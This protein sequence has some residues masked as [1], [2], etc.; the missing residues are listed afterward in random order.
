MKHLDLE[1]DSESVLSGNSEGKVDSLQ[2]ALNKLSDEFAFLGCNKSSD[3]VLENAKSGKLRPEYLDNL[4]SNLPELMSTQWAS[5]IKYICVA[6]WAIAS[7]EAE[8]GRSDSAWTTLLRTQYYLG[9]LMA[10]YEFP[11][12]R[13]RARKGGQKR[14]ENRLRR[15]SM[16]H[17]LVIS[18]LEHQRPVK[19]WTSEDDTV[20]TIAKNLAILIEDQGWILLET[21]FSSREVSASGVSGSHEEELINDLRFVIQNLL[22]ENE[23]IKKKYKE[24]CQRVRKK[25]WTRGRAGY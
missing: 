23:E 13:S 15:E 19:G 7:Y 4:I 1:T 11:H 8:K 20:M 17:Y 16:L 9:L 6:G 24:T 25:R 14:H 5:M 22:R 21:Q 18:Q 10:E 12:E 2:Q 3:Q